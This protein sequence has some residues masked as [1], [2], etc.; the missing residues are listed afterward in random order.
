MK[1]TMYEKNENYEIYGKH[2]IIFFRKFNQSLEP[3][4]WIISQLISL[5]LKGDF[6]QT[7]VLM[8]NIKILEFDCFIVH[9]L[10]LTKNIRCLTSMTVIKNIL[11][12]N[13]I[14]LKL[15]RINIVKII[16]MN[17]NIKY[18]FLNNS[19]QHITKLGKN[20]VQYNCDGFFESLDV[21]NKKMRHLY[22]SKQYCSY[23]VLPKKL[24]SLTIYCSFD[25]PIVLTPH[26]KYLTVKSRFKQHILLEY[27]ISVLRFHDLDVCNNF[28]NSKIVE[29]IPNHA[30]NKFIGL[31]SGSTHV[32]NN[33]PN[34]VGPLRLC[35]TGRKKEDQYMVYSYGDMKNFRNIVPID[36][37]HVS[38]I[39]YHLITSRPLVK[40]LFTCHNISTDAS[41]A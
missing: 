7:F 6:N 20:I 15:T 10:E 8:P 3:Y 11:P 24:I 16:E 33:M 36:T 4:Y 25:K 22:V 40:H 38:Q 2:T 37:W 30:N 23:I 27:P 32:L 31:L 17:K 35:K 14:F 19:Y 5:I 34:N 1:S 13:M 12:K 41:T 18:L 9:G 28:N 26:L 21:I 39:S 29:N